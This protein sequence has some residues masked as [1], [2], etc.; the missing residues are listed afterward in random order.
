[1]G[2]IAFVYPNNKRNQSV[3]LASKYSLYIFGKL[4]EKVTY[5]WKIKLS[6][7]WTFDNDSDLMQLRTSTDVQIRK[8]S[9][10]FGFPWKNPSVN[11]QSWHI[12]RWVL[13]YGLGSIIKI[14]ACNWFKVCFEY[15][16]YASHFLFD[17]LL[18]DALSALA[19]YVPLRHFFKISKYTVTSKCIFFEK[20]LLIDDNT[21]MHFLST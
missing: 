17:A 3:T 16:R 8:Y 10:M 9:S 1:M 13:W 5:I 19:D 20:W 12:K 7:P 21:D 18:F 4:M 6:Q 15:S 14:S 2:E 11:S